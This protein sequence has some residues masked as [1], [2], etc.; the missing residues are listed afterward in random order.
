MTSDDL[1]LKSSVIHT[2]LKTNQ[3]NVSEIL[4]KDKEQLLAEEFRMRDTTGNLPLEQ[5]SAFTHVGH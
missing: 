1:C 3:L 4:Q 5:G 2:R